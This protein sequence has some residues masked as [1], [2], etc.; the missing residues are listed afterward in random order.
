[1]KNYTALLL[2]LLLTLIVVYSFG[3][4]LAIGSNYI[5]KDF[6]DSPGY[7]ENKDE[8]VSK[9]EY[10]VLNPSDKDASI[11]AIDVTEDEINYYR[12]YYGTEADQIY[13]VE[14]QYETKIA[15]ANNVENP[16]TAY[17]ESLQK[18]R[19]TKITEIQK[20]F[21][22]DQVVKDKIIAIKTEI[23]NRYFSKY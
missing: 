21:A 1:M 8:F 14:Q 6:F 19:D 3:S 22:D 13:S 17:I 12:N 20:N 9:L 23:L 11:K 5:G 15:E 2:R 16:N 18:E 7:Q 4:L 10:Y